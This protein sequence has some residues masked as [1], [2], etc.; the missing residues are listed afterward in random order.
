MMIPNSWIV[1]GRLRTERPWTVM[2]MLGLRG[3][4]ACGLRWEHVDFEHYCCRPR[5]IDAGQRATKR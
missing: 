3:S 2:V 4:E 5:R 1:I